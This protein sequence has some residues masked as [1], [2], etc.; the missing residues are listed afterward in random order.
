MH[1]DFD[2]IGTSEPPEAVHRASI[3]SRGTETLTKKVPQAKNVPSWLDQSV[4]SSS[5]KPKLNGSA[6]IGLGYTMFMPE[7]EDVSHNIN[8]MS[9]PAGSQEVVQSTEYGQF[10]S[11]DPFDVLRVQVSD[12][13]SIPNSLS[14]PLTYSFQETSIARR[15]HRACVEMAYHVILDPARRPADIERIFRLSLLGRDR[16]KIA[17]SLKTVLD[18]GPHE[19]LDFWESPLIHVGGAGTHYPH[20]DP[21]GNLVPRKKL[22]NVGIIGPQNLALLEN[23]ARDKISTELT[24]E[25]AGYEGE[26]FDPYD[27]QGYLEEKGIFIDPSSSFA[28]ADIVEWGHMSNQGSIFSTYADPQTPPLAVSRERSTPL[29]ETQVQKLVSEAD[30]D[31]SQWNDYTNMQLTAVGYSDAQSGSWMNFVQPGQSIINSVPQT[32]ASTNWEG[33]TMDLSPD[34]TSIAQSWGSQPHSPGPRRKSV[35]IDV[36]KFVKGQSQCFSICCLI[37]TPSLVMTISGV[38]LGRSPGFR[39]RDVDRALAI[40]SFDAF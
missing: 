26:W 29:T 10:S 31:L 14:P 11:E 1:A 25:L 20:R 34:T 16:V 13:T 2:G 39:R 35:I 40:S 24:V 38:C 8:D 17:A 9:F 7:N 5:I 33:L 22:V 36:S 30:A 3:S 19:D 18:R 27:V 12:T 23:A 6:D 37:L 28:E 21:Y 15:I 32:S 4:V